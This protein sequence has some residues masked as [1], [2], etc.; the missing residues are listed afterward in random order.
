MAV[1]GLNSGVSFVRLST[2]FMFIVS[3]FSAGVGEK[4]LLDDGNGE[5]V[6]LE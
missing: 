4:G 5:V 6:E 2:L 3:Q 1:R